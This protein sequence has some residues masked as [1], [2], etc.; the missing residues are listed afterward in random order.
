[1]KRINTKTEDTTTT[2]YRQSCDTPRDISQISALPPDSEDNDP[3][4]FQNDRIISNSDPRTHY[5]SCP[6][7][8]YAN[9]LQEFRSC[10]LIVLSE[11]IIRD[12]NLNTHLRSWNE[13]F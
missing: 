8:E 6:C 13:H 7:R 11:N 4:I 2:N 12:F 9:N 10:K 5:F 1:M 3:F